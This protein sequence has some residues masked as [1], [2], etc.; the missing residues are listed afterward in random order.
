M[1]PVPVRLAP[2]AESGLAHIVQQFLEQDQAQ[3]EGKRRRAA[4]LRGRIAMTAAD[5]GATVTLEFKGDEIAIHDGMP[6]PVDASITGP[7][8]ALVRLLQ[9]RAHPLLEHL[10]GRL[11]VRSRPG[12]LLFP[13]R[14]H[15]LMKLSG[16]EHAGR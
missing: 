15:R 6:G 13:L 2:G 4:R 1:D 3:F 12:R 9:G 8:E 16:G 11:R 10:R 14:L 7:H 5:H